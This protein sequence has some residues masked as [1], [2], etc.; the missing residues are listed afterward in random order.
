M[1]SISAMF[2]VVWQIIFN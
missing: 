2:R 1:W